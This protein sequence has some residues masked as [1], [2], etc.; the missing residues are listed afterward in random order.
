MAHLHWVDYGIILI[1]TL[2]VL[3]GLIRGFVR[4]LIA[5]C[6]WV[7]AI[8]VGYT[9]SPEVSPFLRGYL[10][11]G[12]LRT[13]ISFILLLL[14][15]LLVGGLVSTA[16]S[17]ILNRSPL[18]GTDRLLGMGFGLVRGT[19]IVALLIGVVNLTSLAK[20][21]EFKQSQ[22]YGRFKPVS[23]WMFG[24]MPQVLHEMNGLQQKEKRSEATPKQN[25]SESTAESE[26]TQGEAD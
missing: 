5:L 3:T 21:S 25:S 11:D 2:S 12:A 26:T 13:T 4:E 1:L 22:L 17:F 14:V 16:L 9:Y 10:H 7:T 15:T 8:W 23:D 18:K 6:V 19:F 24:F 20:E